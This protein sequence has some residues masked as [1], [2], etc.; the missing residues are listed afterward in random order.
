MD[1]CNL[2]ESAAADT[3]RCRQCGAQGRKV[4]RETMENLL[5]PEALARLKDATYFFDRTLECDVV[6]FSNKADSYFAKQD[7]RVRVGIKETEPPVPI[8][9]C[10]GHTAESARKEILKTGHS[11]VADRITAEVQ[12]GNCACEV[13]NPSGTCCLGEVNQVVSK[14]RKELELDSVAETKGGRSS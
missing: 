9:Y 10:F 3:N 14:I 2:P 7:L 6:Y 4:H 13:T 12:A 1:C 8:C 5:K 11:T